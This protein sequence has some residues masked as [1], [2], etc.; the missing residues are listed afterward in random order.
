MI[1]GQTA[2]LLPLIMKPSVHATSVAV[3]FPSVRRVRSEQILDRTSEDF[4]IALLGKIANRMS[5]PAPLH[6]VLYE[7]VEVLT[8]VVKCDSCMVYVLEKDDLVL[9]ASK[10]PHPEVVDR[11]KIKLGQGITGWVAEH[12]EPVIVSECAYEDSRFK[13]FNELPEDRFESFLSVPTVSGGHLVGVINLQNRTRYQYSKRE[14]SLVATLG[15]L[16]GGEI[17]RAR[18]ET[19]NLELSDQLETR[20]LVERAKGILQRELKINEEESYQTLQRESQ[21]RRKSM[22]EVAEAIILT[23]NLMRRR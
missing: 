3:N 22:K 7:V 9:R 20:K 21:Q 2:T 5:V 13:L 15:F 6:D 11:L 17:E 16:V 19:E 4:E 8:A 12:R 23:E 18:L 10:N 1:V 14:I